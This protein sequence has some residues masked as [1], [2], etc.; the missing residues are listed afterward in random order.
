MRTSP[1]VYVDQ[2]CSNQM[3]F[4]LCLI[5]T[6]LVGLIKLPWYNSL[7][8]PVLLSVNLTKLRVQLKLDSGSVQFWTRNFAMKAERDHLH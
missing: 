3:P 1:S 4:E 5:E 8:S 6:V 7:T 2:F